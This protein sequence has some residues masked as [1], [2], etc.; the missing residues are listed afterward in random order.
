[1]CQAELDPGE[2]KTD[3][4]PGPTELGTQRVSSH[5]NDYL[6]LTEGMALQERY[7]SHDGAARAPT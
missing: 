2:N 1:M 3:T 4:A 5:T 6:I 7:R